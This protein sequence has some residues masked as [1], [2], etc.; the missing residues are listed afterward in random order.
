MGKE[1]IV[2]VKDLKQHFRI[3][4]TYTA[5]AVNG[6][7]FSIYENEVFGL[8]GE[9]GCGK[10]T[11]ARSVSG[12]YTPTE[13]EI[14]YRGVKVSGKSG[15]KEQKRLM[16][17]EVQMVFQDSAAA[18]NPRMTVEKILMEPLKIQKRLNDKG[19][20]LAR[21][22]EIL[23]S[24]G[25]DE[26]CI[27]KVPS[28]LS[29]GQRQRIAI[30]RSLMLEP[31]LLIADEP[32]ASL[33]ISIQAQ[34]INLLK[35]CKDEHRFSML[36]IAHDLSVVRFISDRIGVMLKGQLVEMAPAEELFA[37]PIHPYTKSLLSAIHVPDPEY[38][39]NKK[40]IDY[41]RNLPLGHTMIEHGNGHLVL[42]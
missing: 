33:D 5:Y 13:G 38:E 12:I 25:M 27:T 1:M 31:K 35:R 16:Q 21:M 39:R 30:A 3:S 28:E 40:I 41:D 34:I 7:S 6:V 26:S 32:V 10:S 42:E 18:L 37:N 14:L 23:N 36:F 4:D 20:A 15:S 29:G 22:R 24:V 2:E 19:A 11:I 9:T 17:R 8:V